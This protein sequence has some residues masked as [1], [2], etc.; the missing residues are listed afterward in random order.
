MI[1]LRNTCSILVAVILGL[2]VAA[3]GMPSTAL[4]LSGN[5]FQSGRIID[6]G[7]FYDSGSMD[8]AG[9]QRFLEAKVPSCDTAGTRAYA[10]TTAA[11]YGTSKGFPPPYT[12]IRDLRADT[13]AK[14]WEEGICGGY[15]QVNQSAAE[16]IYGVSQSCGINPKVLIVLLQKEQGLITDNWPWSSQYAKATGYA[17][18]DTAACNTQYAGYFNQ[19]YSA[20]RQFKR[21]AKSPLSYNY[22]AGRNNYIAYS[23]TASCGGTSVYI[24]NQAT[25]SLYNY[26]PY[27]PNAGALANLSD[28][29][30]G[31]T[32]TCGAYGNR[33]FWWYFN[34]WF[35]PTLASA[36]DYEFVTSS[37]T[38]MRL[39]Y[40]QLETITIKLRN[41][42]TYTWYSEGSGQAP[43]RLVVNSYSSTPLA[44]RSDPAWLSGAQIKL[45][46]VS[47]APGAVGT[48]SFRVRGTNQ[49]PT[50]MLRFTPVV[51]GIRGM[52]DKNLVF[53]VV[54]GPPLFR[55]QSGTS[56]TP[57]VISNDTLRVLI[58][59]QNTGS[60][61]WFSDTYTAAN[62]PKIRLVNAN[63]S[64]VD[65]ADMTSEF[66]ASP[67][68][69]KMVQQIVR[70]G[71][72]ADFNVDLKIPATMK[73]G[74]SY[75]FTIVLDGVSGAIGDPVRLNIDI[76]RP[77]VSISELS[78]STPAVGDDG[79]KHIRIRALNSGN[80]TWRNETT[81]T[82]WAPVRL[83]TESPLYG[84]SPLFDQ[85]NAS[86]LSAA[87]VG[88]VDAVVRPGS[89][90]TFDFSLKDYPVGTRVP[91]NFGI[92][93]DG[94][95]DST[96]PRI[97]F[98]A[99][100]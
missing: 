40:T 75:P 15:A 3:V 8:A 25:A 5:D 39:D 98:S 76:P 92:T 90:G 61:A 65:F 49:A 9:I 45:Q 77:V 37:A 59:V 12:C 36:Y 42:G 10:G 52:R 97:I 48:F 68:Q 17:C 22:I 50:S 62:V 16:I 82:I 31:G 55:S 26:T 11:Q 87:Q 73:L 1:M 89:I 93:L 88:M 34:N 32:A 21:Y 7:I 41:T 43:V 29:N 80:T 72:V 60:G 46:D 83:V 86:W 66:W 56:I 23:P 38:N 84:V 14:P 63:Y 51:D 94:R 28:T 69:V 6:D 18:P 64:P 96:G 20:A 4:A 30:S 24:Q 100:Y 44:D 47:V 81:K 67:S 74:H 70:P 57:K 71:E 58:K 13:T 19:V 85:G 53:N 33:N 27:Q 2:I 91:A 99:P 95:T 78:V 35:G 79:R 54:S